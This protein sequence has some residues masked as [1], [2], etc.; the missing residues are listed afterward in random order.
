MFPS[1]DHSQD[2]Q[3]MLMKYIYKG[4]GMPGVG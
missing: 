3:D 1:S 2:E 4:M